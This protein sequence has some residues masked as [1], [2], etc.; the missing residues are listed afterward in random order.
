L[1]KVVYTLRI[2]DSEG[3][4]PVPMEKIYRRM[5]RHPIDILYGSPKKVLEYLDKLKYK[6]S[7]ELLQVREKTMK[8]Q[9][10]LERERLTQGFRETPCTIHP[11]TINYVAQIIYTGLGRRYDS[12]VLTDQILFAVDRTT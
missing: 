11:R 1:Q 12:G 5:P 7:L 3:I 6:L 9:L 10:E 2:H 8:I 4:G